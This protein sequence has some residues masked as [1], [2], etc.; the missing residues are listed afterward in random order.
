MIILN[1]KPQKDFVVLNLT[2]VQ[3]S[4]EEWTEGAT[5][6]NIAVH[7]ITQLIKKTQPD[8]ITLSG[9]LAW[10]GQESAYMALANF[11]ESFNI[12]WALIWGNHDNQGGSEFVEKIVDKYL[13]CPHCVYERGDESLG[14][15][16]Y[17]ILIKEND[18]PVEAIIMMDSHDRFPYTNEKGE[19]DLHWAKVTPEQ[20]VWY[21][22]QIASLKAQGCADATVM[23]H[24]PI[25][26]YREASNE[27]Y[28]EGINL[29]EVSLEQSQNGECWKDGYTDSYGVQYE[30]ISSYPA[31]DGMFSAMKESGIT[32]HILV[33]HDHVNNWIIRY[34][35]ICMVYALKTGLGCYWNPILNGG[36]VLK[37][38]ENGVY[39][40]YHEYVDISDFIK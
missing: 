24:I 3:L 26:A 30:A 22:Q 15:G 29:Q 38:N 36:T 10:A 5:A 2:D 4:A 19:T 1:K 6:R 25:Y 21:K 39:D 13:A 18:T 17:V 32:K 23:M 14:N 16:N 31:E 27:A 9:D 28:K 40:V 11:L 33:G 37:I 35:G 7:T 12:P 34:Q 20:I 8:L